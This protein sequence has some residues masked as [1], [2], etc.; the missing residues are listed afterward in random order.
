MV[1]K[2][3]STDDATPRMI[4]AVINHFGV[5]FKVHLVSETVSQLNL[6]L[7]AA[8]SSGDLPISV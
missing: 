8:V 3:L 4:G 1:W 2:D 7:T 5:E 6:E